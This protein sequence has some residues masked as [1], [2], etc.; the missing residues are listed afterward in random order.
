MIDE[1]AKITTNTRIS[2]NDE[3]DTRTIPFQMINCFCMYSDYQPLSL[4]EWIETDKKRK[5]AK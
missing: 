1:F 4:D 5:E 3:N 2:P